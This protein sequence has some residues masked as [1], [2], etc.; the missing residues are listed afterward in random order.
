MLA[1]EA[2]DRRGLSRGSWRA[3]SELRLVRVIGDRGGD[4]SDAGED[5][6]HEHTEDETTDMGEE[7][8]TTATGPVRVE[9]REVAF[10]QLEQKPG[11]EV[12]PRRDQGHTRPN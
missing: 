2:L 5:Y 3:R 6:R 1:F 9:Q 10:E 12:E 4:S 7:S 8:N 11:A